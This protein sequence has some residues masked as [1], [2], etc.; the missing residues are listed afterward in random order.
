M[1]YV[2]FRKYFTTLLNPSEMQGK[3]TAIS[4]NARIVYSRRKHFFPT[5]NI[6]LSYHLNDFGLSEGKEQNVFDLPQIAIGI[7]FGFHVSG[8]ILL[9][10]TFVAHIKHRLL[11]KRA[12]QTQTDDKAICK[13]VK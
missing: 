7:K 4:N 1:P 10:S 9:L 2:F 13:L 12:V 3:L 8:A 11:T 5:V 6:P